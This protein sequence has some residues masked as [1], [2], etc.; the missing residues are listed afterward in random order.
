M[1]HSSSSP[2]PLAGAADSESLH[3]TAAQNEKTQLPSPVE[4]DTFLSGKKLA[5]VFVAM[6]LSMFLTALDQTILATAL[7]RIAS[8]F[9]SFSLQGW[10]SSAF[11][12]AQAVFLL[13]YGQ[14]LRILPAKW[15]LISSITIFE[16]GSLLCGVSQNIDQLI[17]G[18]TVSGLGA[19]GISAFPRGNVYFDLTS[20]P[21]VVAMI[22]VIAQTTRLQDRPKLFGMFGALFG[23]ASVVGPLIGGGLTDHV[24]W[25]WCFWINLPFGGVSVCGVLFMVKAAP[26]LGSDP[27]KRSNRDIFQQILRMD[28]VGATLIAG[29]VTTLVLALQW[30]GNTKPWS[31]KAVIICFVFAAVLTAVFIGWESYMGDR[32]MAPTTIFKSRSIYSLLSYSFLSRFSLLIYS[33]YIPIFYQAS[34]GHS[35]TKSGLD[36]LPFM[37]GVVVTVLAAGQIVSR[38]GRYWS[39]LVVAPVFLAIG[40]GLLYTLTPSTSSAKLVGFQI[41]AGVGIGMGMQNAL[42]AI[43]VEFKDEKKL[44]AQAMSMS[45]FSQFLGGTIGLAIAEPVFATNLAKKLA[46][47]APDAPAAIV[48]ESPTAIFSGALPKE[49]IAGVV[50]SYTESLRIVFVLGVPVAGLALLSTLMIKNIRIETGAKGVH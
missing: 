50:R 12:L 36:L 32:A 9:E 23:L 28:Y 38:T 14:L 22:Q 2:Q 46:R 29:A 18:R 10:V 43:Q 44:L 31:D 6:M 34:R 41:L 49:M 17:A 1:S 48:K 15:V 47:Y 21:P 13:F 25:R 37:L 20:L 45:T 8:D 26:P 16:A 30:G 27:T 39:F 5:V 42:L 40:S 33:Y 19:A 4:L 7:P 24:T 11:I 3:S 35:A